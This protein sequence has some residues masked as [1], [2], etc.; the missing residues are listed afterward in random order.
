MLFASLPWTRPIAAEKRP[1]RGLMRLGGARRVPPR[2]CSHCLRARVLW[3]ACWRACD[4]RALL[5]TA[6]NTSARAALSNFAVT[7]RQPRGHSCA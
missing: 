1:R 4:Q 5:S 6:S 2:A 7:S 3:R